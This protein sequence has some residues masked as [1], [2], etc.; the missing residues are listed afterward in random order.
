MQQFLAEPFSAEEIISTIDAV[1]GATAPGLDGFTG[2]FYKACKST[3]APYLLEV[4]NEALEWQILPPTLREAVIIL[5]P[6]PAK[7]PL[8]CGSY[9]PLSLLN[10]DYKILA[11]ML[12]LRLALLIDKIISP[13]QSGFVPHRSTALNLCTL[14]ADLHR[15]APE[16]PTAAVT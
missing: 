8:L 10:L 12:A 6:K 11:T 15:I 14:F 7:D 5:L 2:N 1:N 9:R 13:A 16:V 3:L 4:Y